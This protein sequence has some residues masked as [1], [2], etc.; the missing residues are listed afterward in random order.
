[1]FHPEAPD[2]KTHP[3]LSCRQS[4]DTEIAIRGSYHTAVQQKVCVDGV[5]LD[6]EVWGGGLVEAVDDRVIGEVVF[7]LVFLVEH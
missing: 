2:S 7:L 4:L 5:L 3:Q 1:M 6:M